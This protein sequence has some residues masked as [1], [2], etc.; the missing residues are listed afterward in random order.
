MPIIKKIMK[1]MKSEYGAK[2]W[3]QVYYAMEN[4]WK[5]KPKKKILKPKKK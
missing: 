5:I 3:E 2:K 4:E 1:N